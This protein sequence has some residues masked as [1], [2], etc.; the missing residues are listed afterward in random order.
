MERE[1]SRSKLFKDKYRFISCLWRL[2]ERSAIN[3][4]ILDQGIRT[5]IFWIRR[6]SANRHSNGGESTDPEQIATFG[7]CHCF[8]N[9]GNGPNLLELQ[10]IPRN[11]SLLEHGPE[12]IRVACRFG[13]RS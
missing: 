13:C 12:S 10:A 7:Q 3:F 4:Q 6:S 9:C 8:I 1:A 11:A 5:V 2:L